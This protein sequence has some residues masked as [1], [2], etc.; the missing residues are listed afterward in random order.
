[1]KMK[2]RKQYDTEAGIHQ[3]WP[4]FKIPTLTSSNLELF[5]LEQVR[6]KIRKKMGYKN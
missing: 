5:E 3:I 1:M 4:E 2:R 6:T